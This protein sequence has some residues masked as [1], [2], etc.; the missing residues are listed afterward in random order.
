MYVNVGE[1]RREGW[2]EGRKGRENEARE[3]DGRNKDREKRQGKGQDPSGVNL[4]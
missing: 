2:G 3:M 1:G 4:G